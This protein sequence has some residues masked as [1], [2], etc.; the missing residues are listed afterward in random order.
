MVA[1]NFEN[2]KSIVP[3]V[4]WNLLGRISGKLAADSW[5]ELLGQ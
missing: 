4:R 5:D 1:V 3:D 2:I